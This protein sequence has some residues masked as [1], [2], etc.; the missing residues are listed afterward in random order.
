MNAQI[1]DEAVEWLVELNSG[2]ADEVDRERF[3]R[4][5]RTSPEHVRAYLE[6]LPAWEAG[7]DLPMLPLTGEPLDVSFGNGADSPVT[8]RARLTVDDLLAMG[9]GE[10][11]NVVPIDSRREFPIDLASHTSNPT[12]GLPPPSVSQRSSTRSKWML[13]AS[14]VLASLLGAVLYVQ[15]KQGIYSAGIGEQRTV[16]LEDGSTVELNSRSKVRVRYSEHRRNVELLSG[17]ALFSVSHDAQRPFIV[18]TDRTQVRAV[19]TQFDVYRKSTG[20]VVTVVEGR[21]AVIPDNATR[22]NE[23][24]ELS[25]PPSPS[26]TLARATPLSLNKGELLLAAGEELT[27]SPVVVSKPKATNV[28]KAIAWTQRRLVFEASTLGEV[29]EE[30]NRYN[31]RQLSLKDPTLDHFPITAAFSSPN[32]SSLIRFL[33]TQPDLDVEETPH[34]I[35]ISRR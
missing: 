15:A 7:I 31:T 11:R 9:R 17:Q 1:L 32:P 4:W 12:L 3:D 5:L 22:S 34:E 13:A 10:A 21:V 25:E 33:R 6:L 27:V 18:T 29:I 30:F 24:I 2:D 19:G 23:P 26:D 35:L 16:Q 14:I 28:A 8:A 20:I